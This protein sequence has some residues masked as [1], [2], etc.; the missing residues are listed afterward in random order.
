MPSDALR[1]SMPAWYHPGTQEGRCVANTAAS[2]CLRVRHRVKT[3][4]DHLRSARRLHEALAG[5]RRSDACT[6]VACQ[7]D[8]SDLGCAHPHRCAMTAE[9]AVAKLTQL[10]RPGGAKN[11]DGLSLTRRRM[12]LNETARAEKG[13]ITFDP[14]LTQGTPLA[15]VFRVFTSSEAARGT[16]MREQG[17]FQMPNEAVEVFTDGSCLNNGMSNACAGSGVWFGEHD[18]RNEGVR[19]P[20]REQSNQ[21][22]EM[23]AVTVA[24]MKIAPF[25]P[26]HVVSD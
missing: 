6:C 7:R 4:D 23:Y 18:A 20:H 5:H 25:A 1:R 8:R 19:V 2:K 24:H 10:W 14:S 16:A 9:R 11:A 15:S 17:R 21:A 26:M 12:R 3:I 22:A 13:R